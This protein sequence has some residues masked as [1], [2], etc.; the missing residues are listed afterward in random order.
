M[1]LAGVFTGR[2][3]V[4]ANAAGDAVVVWNE[5]AFAGFAPPVRLLARRYSAATGTWNSVDVLAPSLA[6]A[7]QRRRRRHGRCR[8][9]RGR[10]ARHVD[11]PGDA[12]RR[13][14]RLVER[15]RQPVH[16][17][18]ESGRATARRGDAPTGDALVTWA[19]LTAVEAARWP[20]GGNAWAAPVSIPAPGADTARAALDSAG[21]AVVVWTTITSAAA[22]QLWAARYAADTAT[23]SGPAA[24]SSGALVLGYPSVAMDPLE[25]VRAVVAADASGAP[26]PAYA[27]RLAATTGTWTVTPNLSD[28]T[29]EGYG[30]DVS[31]D[32][33]GNGSPSGS[34]G[35]PEDSSATLAR[36]W[37]ATPPAPKVTAVSPGTGTLSVSFTLTPPTSATSLEYSLD[38]GATWIP[39]SPAGATSPVVITGLTDGVLQRL[40]LRG[41]NAAGAGDA[42][43]LVPVR[44]GLG[45]T[46]TD[47]RVVCPHRQHRDVRL[48]RTVAGIVPDGYLIEGGL[49]GQT[50]VLASV[51]TGGVA[52]QVTLAVPNG[53]FFVRVVAQR[54]TMPQSASPPTSRSP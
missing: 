45:S 16:A 23:W 47:F 4:A 5:L 50:Q 54:G 37:A 20:A 3:L 49:A 42:S 19:R 12:I 22:R 32:A 48:G 2:A 9:H 40:R 46:T 28:P 41:L 44:S 11:G 25:R 31:V 30:P 24:L 10:V 38:D 51:P 26:G 18:F 7:P 34:S 27:A 6:S 52:A 33:T 53:V 17:D 13:R 29:H 14:Y 1:P 35:W 8:Q 15:R 43:D 39:V 21:N 36:R